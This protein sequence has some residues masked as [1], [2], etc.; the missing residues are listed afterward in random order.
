MTIAIIILLFMNFT[1]INKLDN[2][3]NNI[4]MI[5]SQ[6]GSLSSQIGGVRAEFNNLNQKE[7]L[8]NTYNYDI[9][10]ANDYENAN[11]N[12]D[13]TLNKLKNNSKVFLMYRNYELNDQDWNK[14]E[15]KNQGGLN[16]RAD[17]QLSYDGN[18][19]TELL[20]ENDLEKLS[21]KL[22]PIDLKSKLSNRL[23]MRAMPTR[24]DSNGNFT[25][26]VEVTNIFH[27]DENLR[28]KSLDCYIYYKDKL[29]H[30]VDIIAKGENDA[31]GHEPVERWDYTESINIEEIKSADGDF[32]RDISL[33][34]VAIDRL[35]KKYEYEHDEF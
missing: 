30:Q 24:A 2:F 23:E 1:L 26:E 10:N 25:Y 15:L 32:M 16:Y 5:N 8:I 35:D 11:V 18:Y 7:R 34:L 12:V 20:V 19:E 31:F 27:D 9:Q 33:K 3:Q 22:N 17:L 21:E 14:I 29:V 6:I 28:L 13:I 4:N